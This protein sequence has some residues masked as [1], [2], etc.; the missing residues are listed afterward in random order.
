MASSPGLVSTDASPKAPLSIPSLRP[1]GFVRRWAIPIS[2]VLF[3]V[4]T[5]ARFLVDVDSAGSGSITLLYTLP[6]ALLA[7]AEGAGAGLAGAGLSIILVAVWSTTKDVDITAVDYATRA[8][9][10]GT[11]GGLV[12][13][14]ADRSRS[15][16]R[17]LREREEALARLS[18]EMRE[19]AAELE[20]SNADLERFA[21]VASHD[22][23]EPL[24]TISGFTTLLGRRYKGQLDREADEF[25]GFIEDGTRRMQELIRALL[26]LSRAGQAAT[27]PQRVDLAAAL[28]EVLNSLHAQIRDQDATVRA[29]GLPAVTGDPAQL[30]QLLQNLIANAVKFRT[31]TPPVVEVSARPVDGDRVEV[32]I[33]DNGIG[34]PADQAEQIFQPFHRAAAG[35][36]GTGIG[37]AVCAR[38]V[39]THRGRIWVEPRKEGGTVFRFTLPA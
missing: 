13:W 34:V 4:I 17:A 30:R 20:R 2:L 26:D 15:S 37:L 28:A 23:A 12:G 7:I 18:H 5:L 27:D 32:S 36:E 3:A 6:I 25:I 8:V 38:I 10:F 16:L 9:A 33:A 1:E 19:R 35:H 39:A 29:E 24:R 21:Y 22:L 11:T 31:E 14:F